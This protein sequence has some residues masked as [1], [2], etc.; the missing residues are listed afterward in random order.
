MS[1]HKLVKIFMPILLGLSILAQPAAVFA[2]DYRDAGT[3]IKEKGSYIY[4]SKK[5][6]GIK[7]DQQ[8]EGGFNVYVPYQSFNT[9][10]DK[11]R[12]MFTYLFDIYKSGVGVT[13]QNAAMLWNAP[14]HSTING[15]ET[16][17]YTK[18]LSTTDN[19][20]QSAMAT[21]NLGDFSPNY[22]VEFRYAGIMIDT[23][24]TQ[25]GTVVT[26]PTF[27]SD[28]IQEPKTAGK[29]GVAKT[30]FV[31]DKAKRETEE[32]NLKLIESN[33][34]KRPDELIENW[35]G[36]S[37]VPSNIPSKSPY[38][39]T[40][41]EVFQTWAERTEIGAKYKAMY[42]NYEAAYGMP[43][44]K[45]L[46]KYMRIDGDIKTQSVVMTIVYNDSTQGGHTRYKTYYIPR[47]VENNIIAY[48]IQILDDRNKITG[49][50]KRILANTTHEYEL[51]M[52]RQ[53][54]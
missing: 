5:Y 52:Q 50:A 34:V 28:F 24:S 22:N 40:A 35:P 36:S 21:S 37:G 7:Y 4:T 9:G 31:Y 8:N 32:H 23:R 53:D 54:I 26:N 51:K 39:G 48:S 3:M 38:F 18:Y 20:Q 33:E 30:Y 43:W 29:K 14:L 49:N 25:K 45:I 15:V 1:K 17:Y 11:F 44:W 27:A 19:D 16:R 47:P 2:A 6:S 13:Y 46:Q 41:Q 10:Q 12:R 42:Q